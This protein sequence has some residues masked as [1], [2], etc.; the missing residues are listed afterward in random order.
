MKTLMHVT[1]LALL[2]CAWPYCCAEVVANAAPT[3]TGSPK[4]AT[5]ACET[6]VTDAI[7]E[8]RGRDVHPVQ[9]VAAKRTVSPALNDEAS[10]RGEGRYRAP[11]GFRTFN[12][13][14][15]FNEKTHA[16]SGVVFSDTSAAPTSATDKPWQPDLT[17]LSPEACD[18][19]TAAA[20]KEKYPRVG[21][22]SFVSNARQLKPAENARVLLEG[23]GGVERA[24]GMAPVA[25]TY[26]CEFDS[27]SGKLVSVQTNGLP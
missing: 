17:H 7:Q 6:A 22:I 8:A 1:G 19:A 25:F 5:E 14:C 18:A 21:H 15:S 12:Y 10:V 9:F 16:P 24:P 3:P 13:S 26:R 2:L 4:S 23:Q 27:A 20:L 11:S